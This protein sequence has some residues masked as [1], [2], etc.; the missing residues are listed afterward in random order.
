MDKQYI[1]TQ[2]V[3]LATA[4]L[5]RSGHD[6]KDFAAKYADTFLEFESDPELRILRS[7]ERIGTYYQLAQDA[8]FDP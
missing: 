7:L 8:Q 1:D 4:R 6:P 5:L 2:A 3:R